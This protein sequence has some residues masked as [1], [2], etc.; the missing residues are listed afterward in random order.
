VQTISGL[1]E[2]FGTP[3]RPNPPH[4]RLGG[5]FDLLGRGILQAA[6]RS[7][8]YVIRFDKG[9]QGFHKVDEAGVPDIM[10][11]VGKLMSRQKVIPLIRS[12]TWPLMRSACSML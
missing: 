4:Y 10:D 9:M 6:C 5:P 7:G 3:L 2:T 12:R 11:V 8:L 1:N